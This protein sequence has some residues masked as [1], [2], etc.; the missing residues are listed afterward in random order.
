MIK[1]FNTMTSQKE[2][3][4]P[5]VDNKVRMY[6]CG[7][8]VY[9]YCHI[10][11][12]RSSIVFDTIRRYLIY[13]GYNVVF[14]KN[15][16]DIDDKI[17]KKS[18][19]TGLSIW[20]VTDKYIK[21]HDEDMKMLNV[22]PPDHTPKATQYIDEMIELCK[23]LIGKGYAY[24]SNG[25]VYFK[26]KS[27]KEYGKLSK[28]D[29]EDLLSGARVEVSEIKKDP[30]DFALWKRS[31][32]NEPGWDSPWGKGRPGW[33]IECSV[34]SSKLLGIPFDIHGGGKDLIFPHHENEIAQS[35]AAE[36]RELANYWIHNGF[37]NID[38]EKMSKSLGNFL[39]I[40]DILKEIDPEVLRFFLLTTHYRSPLDF[41]YDKLFEAENA[42]DRIYTTYDEIESTVPNNKKPTCKNEIEKIFDSFK[43]DFEAAMDDDF[44]TA[45]AIS[46]IFEMIKSVNILLKNRLNEE[47]LISLKEMLYKAKDIINQ[48]LGI[49]TKTPEEW[50]KANLSIEPE[51]LEKLILEREEARK[52]KNFQKADEIRN[53]L[54][55]K[56]IELLDTIKG[57]KFRTKRLR[58]R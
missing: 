32:E 33:H 12:A 27:F 18:N 50:F 16:T 43:T 2:I 10:G 52:S 39:T 25:D 54:Q 3:F 6:V 4:I 23:K 40:R 55:S 38:K 20:K 47:D 13:K 8:T 31:K 11:H 21:A 42:V 45:Q 7:V 28:R 19:E 5:L 36:G 34:M 17:I 30:L 37:V 24:E 58:S 35:E 22:L 9:D 46:H 49:L 14:V 53:L 41:S 29:L 57:T 1:I 44:N 15:F 51:E 48:T 56:G 26:V